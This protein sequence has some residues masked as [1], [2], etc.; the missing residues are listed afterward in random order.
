MEMPLAKA[1]MAEAILTV[2]AN[3]PWQAVT[4][5]GSRKSWML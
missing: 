2:V 3:V 5:I 1:G 4:L